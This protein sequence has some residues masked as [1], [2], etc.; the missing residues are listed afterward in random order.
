MHNFTIALPFS[1]FLYCNK[2]IEH[3][4]QKLHWIF[5]STLAYLFFLSFDNKQRTGATPLHKPSFSGY[6]KRRTLSLIASK[7]EM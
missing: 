2:V 7:T 1:F 6:K 5:N 3:R 4:F